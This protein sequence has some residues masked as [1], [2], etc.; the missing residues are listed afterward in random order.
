MAVHTYIK[1]LQYE[2]LHIEALLCMYARIHV[3]TNVYTFPVY[4]VYEVLPQTSKMN[5]PTAFGYRIGMYQQTM[6]SWLDVTVVVYHYLFH[7]HGLDY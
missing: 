5:N 2:A 1:Q 6:H 4:V 7:L 3:H